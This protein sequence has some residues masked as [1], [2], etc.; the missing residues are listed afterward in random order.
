VFINF[1]PW[2]RYTGFMSRKLVNNNIIYDL[3]FYY[4]INEADVSPSNSDYVWLKEQ[5]SNV[6]AKIEQFNVPFIMGEQG[7]GSRKIDKGGLCDIWLE[8]CLTIHKTSPM[9]QGWLYWCYIAYAGNIEGGGWQIRLIE[10]LA[11]NPT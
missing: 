6:K 8:N 11:E 10:Y 3:H 2:A 5:F 1:S 9:M 7:F 4:G